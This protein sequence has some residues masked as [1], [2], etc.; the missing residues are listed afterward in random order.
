MLKKSW[1]TGI[2][3]F[4]LQ[5]KKKSVLILTG[6]LYKEKSTDKPFTLDCVII[7]SKSYKL[8]FEFSKKN[9]FRIKM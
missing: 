5:K 3:N 7:I 4:T 6:D 1:I 9:K 2:Y 8:I